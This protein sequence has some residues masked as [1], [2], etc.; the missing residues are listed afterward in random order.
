MAWVPPEPMSEAEIRAV[1]GPTARRLG[2][3]GKTRLRA[4]TAHGVVTLATLVAAVL[5]GIALGSDGWTRV[6]LRNATVTAGLWAVA[7]HTAAGLPGSCYAAQAYAHGGGT[8]TNLTRDGAGTSA[9]MVV[10][11]R[12]AFLD[13]SLRCS[14][15]ERAGAAVGSKGTSGGADTAAAAS[16]RQALAAGDLAR[17]WREGGVKR[18]DVTATKKVLK[19]HHLDTLKGF[20]CPVPAQNSGAKPAKTLYGCLANRAQTHDADGRLTEVGSQQQV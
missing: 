2:G 19:V 17:I 3:T 11:M 13:Q 18:H 20:R 6:E 4:G 8:S 12:H 5:F 16:A 7:C 1:R 10:A 15:P 14:L 9:P